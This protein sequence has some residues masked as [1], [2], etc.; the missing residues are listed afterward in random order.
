MAR[1]L[2]KIGYCIETS[3][4]PIKVII[5]EAPNVVFE[6]EYLWND[7]AKK[8]GASGGQYLVQNYCGTF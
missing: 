3:E 1:P 4:L 7:W 5:R 6:E 2:Y 8:D